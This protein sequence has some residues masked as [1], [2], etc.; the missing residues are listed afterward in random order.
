[1]HRRCTKVDKDTQRYAEMHGGMH[2]FAEVC[3]GVQQL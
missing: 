3:L 1:M 2:R